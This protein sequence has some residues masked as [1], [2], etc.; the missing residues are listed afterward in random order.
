MK[1][2]LTAQGPTNRKSYTVTLPL[3]WVKSNKLHK[4][5]EVNL[6]IIQDKILISANQK[7]ETQQ[8]IEGKEYDTSLVKV[9]QQLYRKG[10]NEVKIHFNSTKQLQTVLTLIN[11]KLIG[12]EIIS[13]GKEYVTIKDITKESQE[14]F[15]TLFRRVFLLLLELTETQ[16]K[17]Q[18]DIL[19]QNISKFINYCQRILM[20]QGHSD[21]QN[22]PTYY[23]ILDRLEKLK[24]EF[25]WLREISMKNNSHA[26]KMSELLREIYELFYTF[27]PKKFILLQD[28]TYDLKNEFK[29]SKTTKQE[30]IHLH[31]I[32]RILN[33]LCGDVFSIHH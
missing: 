5:R 21:Y 6:E 28:I 16:N 8:I 24:D 32:S 3:D 29:F 17:E 14:E 10:V 31:N 27:S 15:P 1:K 13:Q 20:K 11:N 33:S 22:I 9:I 25:T 4:T 12:Y 23:L 7:K 18:K 30:T 19:A 26:K 2:K